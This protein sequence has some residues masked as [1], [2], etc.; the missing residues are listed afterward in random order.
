MEKGGLVLHIIFL[1][2]GA[3]GAPPGRA[4]SCLLVETSRTRILLDCGSGCSTRLE[5]FSIAPCDI[6]AIVITHLH[7]D[8][9]AGIFGLAVRASAHT[10]PRFPPL[11]VH[12]SIFEESRSELQR[13]LPRPWRDKVKI[14]GV[15]EVYMVG[16]VAI[17]LAPV[18]HSIPC[19]SIA[20]ESDRALMLYTSDTRPCPAPLQHYLSKADLVV[21][22]ATLPSNLSQT[23]I[24]TGHSTVAEAFSC[25]KFM[26]EDAI[27]ALT[28]LTIESERELRTRHTIPRRILI[29]SDHTVY[30]L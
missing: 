23:A 26:R 29:A 24:E 25:R 1:G 14:A 21:H 7:A 28:H 18:E 4:E 6:D 5:A 20:L 27:L 30:S 2:T 15:D 3:A 13:L 16:D 11:I 10:C 22:E 17:R 19:W 9:Y 8:H 12:R